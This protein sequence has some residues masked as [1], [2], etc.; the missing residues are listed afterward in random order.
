MITID[1]ARKLTAKSY[2]ELE[3]KK[4]KYWLG[5]VEKAI[6]TEAYKGRSVASVLLRVND[7]D[8]D[9]VEWADIYIAQKLSAAIGVMGYKTS[10]TAV[11]GYGQ[12]NIEWYS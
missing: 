7:S 11:N 9:I 5:I 8:G 10:A 2:E 4:I 1:E 12:V 3:G 6:K